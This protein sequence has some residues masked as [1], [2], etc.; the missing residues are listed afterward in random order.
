MW[1]AATLPINQRLLNMCASAYAG[2][3]Q[4]LKK[5]A[6]KEEKLRRKRMEAVLFNE[7]ATE[8]KASKKFASVE[9]EL[10]RKG[11]EIEEKI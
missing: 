8:K 10:D 4:W 9:E 1:T 5:E 7:V 11:N 6:A 3:C 2:Y